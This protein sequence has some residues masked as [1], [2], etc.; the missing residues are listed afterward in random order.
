M[1]KPTPMMEQYL[2][3]KNE[4]QDALLFFRLGDFYELFMEDAVTASRELDI[5]LTSR[6]GGEA[7][8]IPMC[9]I[10]HHSSDVYLAKLIRQGYKVAICEQVE[11]PREARGIVKRE[12]VRIITPGTVLDDNMLPDNSSNYLAAVCSYKDIIGLAFIDVSTADF[13]VSEFAGANALS[14]M[15][16]E[17]QRINPAECLVD[18]YE[19]LL[20]EDNARMNSGMVLTKFEQIPS[21]QEANNILAR[22]FKI[23][24]LEGLGLKDYTAGLIAAAYIIRFLQN[25]KTRWEHIRS[26][27]P[28]HNNEYLYMDASTRKNLELTSTI[29]ENKREGSLISILDYCGTSMGKRL[30]KKWLELPLRN[31]AEINLRLDS[32]A[33]LKEDLVLREELKERL[34]EINDLERLAGRIGAQVATPRDFVGIK[35]SIQRL[36]QIKNR[37]KDCHCKMLLD[38]SNMDRLQD[39]YDLIDEIMADEA[40]ITIRDGNIIKT[41]YNS[42][43]DE[44]RGL[45][46][47]GAGWLVELE[48]REKERTGIKYLKVGFNKVFGYYIEISKSNLHLVP[49]NYIRKQTLVNTERFISEELKSYEDKILGAREKLLAME[50]AEFIQFREKM[51]IYV[52]RI[53]QTAHQVARLDVLFSLAEA[54]YIND[55]IRPV[56][57]DNGI[58]DIK[59]GR[60]PVVEQY[61]T[62]SRFV[63]ND[64]KLDLTERQFAIITGPNMGGKSTY[65]RQTALLTIMAQMGSF[66]PAQNAVIGMVDKVFTRVG[67]SDDLAAGQSTFM[68]EMVE[69]AN[70]L[71]NATA[72]SLIILDEIGRGTSTYDGLSL[73]QA[74]SEYIVTRIGART[75]FATHYHELTKLSESLPEVFNLCVSVKETGDSVVFLKKMLPG[76]ADKSY[77]LHVARL[78]GVNNWV[79]DKAQSILEKL[80]IEPVSA[81]PVMEQMV[82]FQPEH[83]LFE[84]LQKLNVDQLT[85]K[86]A[87]LLIYKWKENC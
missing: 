84:E 26:L 8:K 68:V 48:K 2:N 57:D 37:L 82:L 44:L 34:S 27:K 7:G 80:E 86:E 6:D 32:V 72:N 28:Y 79:I 59:S 64:V 87:L 61:L 73:A 76:K 35:L 51:L 62:D 54:A 45:S 9:G 85:P 63:P 60:H 53:Q 20:W 74:V 67:A 5:V 83:P 43:I 81:S 21:L 19:P 25:G 24:S 23:A 15:A 33:E 38:I 11:D 46:R 3:I 58:I 69:V 41:G 78:A 75:L 14:E 65:M 36:D 55:Y 30:L 12:V 17:L 40:P 71:N 49:D 31:T 1:S 10:P 70:I 4:H 18:L 47:Q 29:R 16:M 66:I 13:Q 39:V 56:V 77:G 52:E 42:E 22:Q 50:Q